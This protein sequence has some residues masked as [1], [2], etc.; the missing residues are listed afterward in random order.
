MSTFWD[1]TAYGWAPIYWLTVSG[2]PVVF[3]ERQLG[4]TLPAGWGLE[5]GSLVIDES[6]EIGCKAIDRE[7]GIG[8]GLD[9]SFKLLDTQVVRDWLRRWSRQATLTQD[10]AAGD[11]IVHV[12]STT[13]WDASGVLYVGLER[14]QYNG[15]TANTFTTLTRATCGSLENTHRTGTT[16]Q[17]IT[18]RPR[19]WRGRDVTLW[20]SMAD[21]SGH[22]C[23]TDLVSQQAQQI[24][25]G[26]I[27]ASPERHPDGFAF[28]AQSVDRILDEA[29]A[30][31]VSGDVVGAGSLY[32]VPPS[33]TFGIQFKAV[34]AAKAAVWDATVQVCPFDGMTSTFMTAQE[35][36]DQISSAW[37]SAVSAGAYTGQLG[38]LSWKQVG[39]TW[40]A[41]LLVYLDAGVYELGGQVAVDG[42]AWA[43]SV[44]FPAG[45]KSAY[46]LDLQWGGTIPP[47]CPTDQ[48]GEQIPTAVT[49]R[50]QDGDA[51]AVPASGR[52]RL[53][54]GD[55]ICTYQYGQVGTDQGD[56]Y[57]GQ[58]VPLANQVALT[59]AQI[60]PG[61]DSKTAAELLADDSGG[62]DQL[63]ARTLESSGTGLR[64][65]HD[66]LPVGQGYGLPEDWIDLD[67]VGRLGTGGVGSLLGH[68]TSS[69]A[70]FADLYGGI[71]SL[72]RLAIVARPVTAELY[73]P[74]RLTVVETAQGTDY[75]TTITDNDLLSHLD[76][77]VVSIKRAES[78]N[79]INITRKPDGQDQEDHLIFTDQT[80][81]EAVGR[82]EQALR[83]DATDR[84]QLATVAQSVVASHFAYDQT[85]QALELKVHPS[86]QAET[87]DAVWLQLTHP[88]IWT[89]S[90]SP[91]QVG[92]QGPGRVTGRTL[93]PKTGIV[94][95][96]VLIDGALRLLALSPA[97]EVQAYAGPAGAATTIDVPAK[98]TDHLQTA[99]LAA[100]GPVKLLHYQPG[101]VE[102]TGQ[103]YQ[104]GAAVLV[105]GVC[106]LTVVSQ[107]GTFSL[108]VSKRSTLTLPV[109]SDS[110]SYQGQ[111]AHA[112][113]GSQ[114]G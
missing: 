106:R 90:T 63:A 99:I 10:F 45:M 76:D 25:R 5:D 97:A 13:G 93:Q 69:G 35:V 49:V 85:V 77:P 1:P 42:K 104:V 67:S 84:D 24:W 95:L 71:M 4:K 39:K 30:G 100:G 31:K 105:A 44:P 80:T 57:V 43:F 51:A 102:G 113:D 65:S 11:T 19:H 86:V 23:G 79:S 56:L 108:D 101:Q 72:F 26:R 96:T 112:D 111:F 50:L 103:S 29:L 59:W 94:T 64:G 60:A 47:F 78:P 37:T 3:A 74:I 32:V 87:G 6:A 36:R 66:V 16:G 92:Y 28:T 48:K 75:R 38:P 61:P 107:T 34:D 82:R 8:T 114:W 12:D 18:D 62:F 110:T 98:Y 83:V 70:S 55:L 81:V 2:V 109:L 58:M 53:K 14:V 68:L 52:I 7:R 21:P 15:K 91:G 27:T 22:V 89:W 40:H 54:V 17:V 46:Q 20:A 73:T 88:S 41:M 33:W 9:L